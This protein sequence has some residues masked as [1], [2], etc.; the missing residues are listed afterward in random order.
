MIHFLAVGRASVGGKVEPELISTLV[1]QKNDPNTAKYTDHATKILGK[2]FKIQPGKRIRLTSDSNF[3]IQVQSDEIGNAVFM[4]IAVTSTDFGS[5]H[6]PGHLFDDWRSNFESTIGTANVGSRKGSLENK[7]KSVLQNILTKFNSSSLRQAQ[8]KAEKVK[9][10]MRDNVG[11][12]MSN[13]QGVDEMDQKSAD[14]EASARQ[15]HTQTKAVKC[16]MCKEKWK[17][18]IIGIAIV[19]IIIAIILIILLA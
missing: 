4:F 11:L 12:A 7:T 5:H 13:L 16:A 8:A 2:S 17:S 3:V 14:I 18:Y 15:F 10:T 19:L 6:S 9:G 1:T